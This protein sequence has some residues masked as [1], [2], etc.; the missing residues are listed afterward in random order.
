MF[1][2][3]FFECECQSDEHTLRFMLDTEEN[4]LLASIFLND[5][6]SF[7]KRFVTAVKYLFG[8]KCK[9]GHWDTWTLRKDDVE[10][11]AYLLSELLACPSC[12]STMINLNHKAHGSYICL[13]CRNEFNVEIKEETKDNVKAS[14]ER[15]TKEQVRE[16]E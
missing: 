12:Q 13:T 8:Y 14:N 4:E 15:E 10:R 9:Y 3:E 7:W 2:S 6:R 16:E 11:L 1:D 5:Y